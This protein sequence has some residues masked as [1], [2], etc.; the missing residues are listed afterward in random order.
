VTVS[1]VLRPVLD[2]NGALL[3]ER[4]TC[5]YTCPGCRRLRGALAR[6]SAWVCSWC[7]EPVTLEVSASEWKRIVEEHRLPIDMSGWNQVRPRHRGER[8]VRA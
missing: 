2:E 4:T 5:V 3:L 7:G 8:T 1:A 6:Y